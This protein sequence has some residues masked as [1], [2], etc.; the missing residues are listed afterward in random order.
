MSDANE[1]IAPWLGLSELPVVIWPES[2][3][4]DEKDGLHWKTRD[5]LGWAAGRPNGRPRA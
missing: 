2:P 1:C 4:E 3:D 5:L